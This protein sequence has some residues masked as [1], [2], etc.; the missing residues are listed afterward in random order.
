MNIN[1]KVLNVEAY[2]EGDSDYDS[3]NYRDE[4]DDYYTSDD[5]CGNSD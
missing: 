3:D 4:P 5:T 2:S 1:L